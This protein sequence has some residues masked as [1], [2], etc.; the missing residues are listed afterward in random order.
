TSGVSAHGLNGERDGDLLPAG[1]CG[2]A[3][4]CDDRRQLARRR[5]TQ[6]A[7]PFPPRKAVGHRR[8]VLRRILERQAAIPFGML[9]TALEELAGAAE[10]QRTGCHKLAAGA[11]ARRPVLKAA[12]RHDRDRDPLVL[13]LERPVAWTR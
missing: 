7:E 8:E 11:G 12:A 9:V 5:Q 3:R 13:L 6:Q 10:Q 2:R 1:R 4:A